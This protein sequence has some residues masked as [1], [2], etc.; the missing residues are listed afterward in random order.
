MERQSFS[1][2]ISSLQ[3]DN[4]LRGTPYPVVLSFD[5]D[6]KGGL[7]S[8]MRNKDG[9]TKTKMESMM[10]YAIG[11]SSEPKIYLVASKWRNKEMM[12]VSFEYINLR[13]V[14]KHPL[15]CKIATSDNALEIYLLKLYRIG[16]LCLELDL[17]L[18]LKLLEFIK[19]NPFLNSDTPTSVSVPNDLCKLGVVDKS[20]S[21]TPQSSEYLR[22]IEDQQLPKT[23]NTYTL[24]LPEVVPIGAPWQKIYLLA[25]RQDKIYVEA[26][27]LAPV[28]M[29]LR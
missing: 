11:I 27:S 3:I 29:T 24:S 14:H 7:V 20:F 19:A 25:R 2:Q 18:L 12:L 22:A 1:F 23:C 21:F 26:F 8:H 9:G 4:Q 6:F 17:E 16:D 10:N 28:K 5:E 15:F 13:C